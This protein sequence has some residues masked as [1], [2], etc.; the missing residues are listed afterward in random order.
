MEPIGETLKRITAATSKGNMEKSENTKKKTAEP[1]DKQDVCPICG[2]IGYVRRDLPID[3]PNFGMLEVCQCQKENFQRASIQRLYRISNLDA[4]KEMTFD[5]FNICG[6]DSTNEVNKTLEVA[7]NTAKNYAH[8]LNGWLLLMGGYGSGKTHLAAA[9]ANELVSLGVETL[10]LTVPDLLDWLRYS[11]GSEETSYESR[12]EEIK[13][14]R[15][16]VLDDLGTQN[17]T[18]W[19]RENLFQIINHRYT[20]K[21]STVITTNIGLN[22][23]DERVRSRLQDR[24]LVIKLQIDAPD[25]R[26]PLMDSSLSPISSLAHISDHRTFDKFSARKNEKLRADEQGSL[27][28]AFLA[29]QEFAE[30][31]QGWLVFM[32]TYGTGKTHLAAAIGHYQAALGNDPIFTVVPD[33]LDHLR[34][35]FNPDSTISYDNVFSQVRTTNLLI[36][37][38]LGTQSAT[39][40]ARE[41]LYQ[42]LNYRYET[43]LPTVI[44]TSSTLDEIDPRIRSRMLDERVCRLYK[45]IVP[46][47]KSPAPKRKTK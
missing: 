9:V 17:T 43:R 24:E 26:N 46:P 36:L 47:Y 34:A 45:I 20:H 13:N 2:G 5:S 29:A 44:T 42:V 19:A 4:F 22:E 18:A 16:L 3:D 40:W 33:L 32:G 31:P 38:D 23:I 35:T 1:K 41:K 28:A 39:P 37:D 12:F 11:F 8:H 6:H 25:F 30:H 15:F 7:F 14:I 21:L 10:F 27:D